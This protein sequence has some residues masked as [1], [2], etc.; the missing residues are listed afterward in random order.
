V[1]GVVLAMLQQL[2]GI[3]AV[4]Y[5]APSIM[6]KAGFHSS[7]SIIYSMILGAVNVAAT[8]VAV[9]LVD[10]VGRRPLLLG[11]TVGCL[12]SLGLLGLAFVLGTN[13]VGSAFPLL[14]LLAYVAS[15]AL[16]FGPVFW[17][18]IAEIFPA[19]ARAAGAGVSTA[20][21]WLAN[22]LV[23]LVFLPLASAVGEGP[24]FWIF[25]GACGLALVFVKSYVPETKGRTLADIDA[26]VRS[27]RPAAWAR[28]RHLRSFR[29]T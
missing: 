5:Y 3:N 24:T 10:R 22:F 28:R 27:A 13:Y 15:F 25:A 23:S 2:C 19:E 4:I 8:V 12:V 7:E 26:E 1:I 9:R 21:N 29:R 16:G 14:C 11:S 20:V 6:A 17:L 18:L